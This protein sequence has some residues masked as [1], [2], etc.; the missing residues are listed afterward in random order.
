MRYLLIAV[1]CLVLTS[2]S[3][4]NDKRKEY[5]MCWDKAHQDQVVFDGEAIGG[6]G[7]AVADDGTA[8]LT[9]KTDSGERA[10][11]KINDKICAIAAE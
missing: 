11:L 7:T 8:F 6:I 9:F 2:C 4:V 1:G 3:N 5:V 10:V